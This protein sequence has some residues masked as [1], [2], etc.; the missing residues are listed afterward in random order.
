MPHNYTCNVI[1]KRVLVAGILKVISK[2]HQVPTHNCLLCQINGNVCVCVYV[3]VLSHID[4]FFS[5]NFFSTIFFKIFFNYIYNECKA[6]WQ[7][8]NCMKCALQLLFCPCSS[9]FQKVDYNFH[10]TQSD[11]DESQYPPIDCSTRQTLPHFIRNRCTRSGAKRPLP[12]DESWPEDTFP[13][14]SSTGGRDPTAHT[15]GRGR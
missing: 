6:F 8:S 15:A 14:G 5:T 10:T 7:I 9:K 2:I 11:D 3:C 12:C 13:V 1:R 4:Q